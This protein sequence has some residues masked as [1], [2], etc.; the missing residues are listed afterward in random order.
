MA[1]TYLYECPEHGEMEIQ[2]GMRVDRRRQRCPTCRKRLKPLVIHHDTYR[3]DVRPF[4]GK[5]H[6]WH[7]K[8]QKLWKEE[9]VKVGTP[10]PVA[11]GSYHT[12]HRTMEELKRGR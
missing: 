8:T 7:Y 12:H 2:H 9:T 3:G 5:G 1:L 11:V 6:N 10:D 4:I